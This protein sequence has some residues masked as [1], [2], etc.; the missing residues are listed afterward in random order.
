MTD[1][2]PQLT[3][4]NSLTR[5]KEVFSPQNPERVTMYNCGPTVYSYAH[6]GNARAAVVAD[7]LFRVLMH[8]YDPE[9]LAALQAGEN[10]PKEKAKVVYARNITD[11]D[12]KIIAAAAEQGIPISDITEKFA[13]IYNEDLAAIG[14][15]P[16]TVQPKA[17]EH[18]G[19]MIAMIAELMR[20]GYAYASEGHVFF[21]VSTFKEYG[22]LSGNSLSALKKGDRVGEGEVSRK[23]NSADFV[24]WKPPLDGV[25]WDAPLG[26]NGENMPGRPGWHIEC[27]AMAKAELTDGT[28]SDTI[29]IH[30]GGVDL[31]FPHHENEIAQSNC[32]HEGAPLANYWV[33]NEFLNMGDEKM[34]KSLGNVKLIHDLLKRYDG[35]VLRL[36]L[37]KADYKS[38][39]VWNNNLLFEAYE[40]LE[41]WYRSLSKIGKV[42]PSAPASE[43]I[44]V[45][46]EDLSTTKALF[47]LSQLGKDLNFKYEEPFDYAEHAAEFLA[48]ANLLGLLQKDPEAWFKGGMDTDRFDSLVAEYDAARAQAVSAKE[49]GDK[50]AMGEAFARSDAIRDELKDQGIA[51]E[52]GPDGS[53]W[54]KA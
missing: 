25:G 5:K 2:T 19:N 41:R 44:N 10:Y 13:R 32:C 22:Q 15:L 18:I 20:K 16:P 49:A 17:T 43:F 7:V 4:Y 47:V 11:V 3:L 27:S 39:L 51:I 45:L 34:S 6:I 9:Q 48:S 28:D 1:Q 38:E 21:D 23:K 12:D 24:L 14:C 54:R 8:I 36:A 31:K 37:I 33:H 40:Q 52:T 50:A 53:S 29:D 30:C 42:K 35:E 26:P 46:N